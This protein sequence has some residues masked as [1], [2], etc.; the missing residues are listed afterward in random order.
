[1]KAH[2]SCKKNSS[3]ALRL[4][5][6]D[7][8][9]GKSGQGTY[10]QTID[11]AR[12]VALPAKCMVFLIRGAFEVGGNTKSRNGLGYPVDDETIL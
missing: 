1:M 9:L 8:Q 6:Y 11:D 12:E 2:V 4:I 3:T 10:E 5:I 7:V